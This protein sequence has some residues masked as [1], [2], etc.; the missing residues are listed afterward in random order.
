MKRLT[1]RRMHAQS[2]VTFKP[3]LSVVAA[4]VALAMLHTSAVSQ[5]ISVP[6]TT[7]QTL[8]A[9]EDLT[10][11]SSGSVMVNR[12]GT[13]PTV[14]AVDIADVYT[15]MFVNR[16]AIASTATA[17]SG[18]ANATTL[19]FLGDIEGGEIVNSGTIA[20]TA[21]G[22]TTGSNRSAVARGIYI[23]G[24]M[25][26]GSIFRGAGDITV[27]ATGGNRVS[28]AEETRTSVE[29]TYGIFLN[30]WVRDAALI[31][32]SGVV[33]L[34]AMSGSGKADNFS[35]NTRIKEVAGI[36]VGRNRGSIIEIRGD[37]RLKA[38]AGDAESDVS[39]NASVDEVAG[40]WFYDAIENQSS[41]STTGNIRV[42]VQ[43]G[44]GAGDG[45]ASL[46]AE[47][48]GAIVMRG[49]LNASDIE[50]RG[51][52]NVVV[53]GGN[54][55]GS[56]GK[57]DTYINNVGGILFDRSNMSAASTLNNR[58]DITILSETGS[59][60]GD[61]YI[62]NVGGI[63]IFDN[64]I[65]DGSRLNN[66]GDILVSARS[67]SNGSS[68]YADKVAGILIGGRVSG[69]TVAN[70]VDYAEL[71]NSGNIT[72]SAQAGFSTRNPD[73]WRH[74][75]YASNIAG[76]SIDQLVRS[77]N[78]ENSGDL[79]IASTGGTAIGGTD[80]HANA[81]ASAFGIRVAGN[82]QSTSG[83]LPQTGSTLSN[84]GSIVVTAKGGVAQASGS[85]EAT[86][87]AS[88]YGISVQRIIQDSLLNNSGPISALATHG[89]ASGAISSQSAN[90]Y[91][92]YVGEITNGLIEEGDHAGELTT[93]S[94]M[95]TG[96]L[97]GRAVGE[98]GVGAGLYVDGAMDGDVTLQG[99]I[100]GVGPTQSASDSYAIY[101]GSGNGTLVINAP[102]Y[103]VGSLELDDHDVTLTSGKSLSVHWKFD[104]GSDYTLLEGDGV[105]WFSRNGNTQ[106]RE[107]ATYYP[108]AQA[109]QDQVMTSVTHFGDHHMRR[110][111]L[112]AAGISEDKGTST[113][114]Y[115]GRSHNDLGS[116]SAGMNDMDVRTSGMVGGLVMNTDNDLTLGLMGGAVVTKATASG[117]LAG[118]QKVDAN[119]GF[120]GATLAKSLN[121][122]MFDGG[123]KLGYSDMGGSRFVNHNLAIAQDGL[124]QAK[125][126]FKAR[127]TAVSLGV[128][129]DMAVQEGLTLTPTAQLSYARVK[130]GG[131]S[132]RGA[133]ANATVDGRNI[134]LKTTDFGVQLKQQLNSG[135]LRG[136]LTY[137]STKASG[138]STLD[139]TLIGNTQAVKINNTSYG[140]PKLGLGYTYSPHKNVTVSF[141]GSALLGTSSYKGLDL[142]AR[143]NWKF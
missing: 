118:I 65:T 136:S 112:S 81:N 53:Q 116:Q 66:S 25:N 27:N 104:G 21:I 59:A 64:S 88:A 70:T 31:S 63:Q 101:F 137:V 54:G 108:T 96:N 134:R 37:V 130:M 93:G 98:D 133:T 100:K 9:A 119:S 32:Q 28:N 114:A 102:T 125:A 120:I 87:T 51:D 19:N 138:P 94:L 1:Q 45:D 85:G 86:A 115:V 29:N 143:L 52:L 124:E 140:A 83:L 43:A 80:G 113:W 68:A 97:I 62:S 49:N 73:W 36:R 91:A 42:M 122:V 39:S 13:D 12:S 67:V 30:G 74:G 90:A 126:D 56:I 117:D 71:N 11:R 61:G 60:N 99:V 107:Y 109:L 7:T 92:V 3:R 47:Q 26:A 8:D 106:S 128:S 44:E 135:V 2:T 16:G 57:K 24:F 5:M 111:L 4:S 132:E 48:V 46:Y 141:D 76:I 33:T 78:V 50:N 75:A 6:V 79:N 105:S 121:G 89:S 139:V 14:S 142:S 123:I 82:L 127:W 55:V 58:G 103:L 35:V 17:T 131:Y 15:G 38:Y 41:V 34:N 10:V 84:T 110:H 23:Q 95:S 18:T 20:A 40:V 72:V 22:G 129:Y 77:G 69:R